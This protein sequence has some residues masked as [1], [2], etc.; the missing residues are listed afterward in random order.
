MIS[1]IL[2][3]MKQKQTILDYRVILRQDKSVGTNQSCYVASCPTLGVTDDGQT[4]QEALDN[5]KSTIEFHLECLQK[6]G[7][8][9]PVDQ[10]REELLTTTQISFPTTSYTRFAM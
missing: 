2:Q 1:D 7:K 5:L 9:I 8:E 3:E 6:E 10:P 4:P